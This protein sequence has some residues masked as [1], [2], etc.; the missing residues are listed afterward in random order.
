MST[1]TITTINSCSS[2]YLA[3]TMSTINNNLWTRPC[4]PTPST[5]SSLF[6]TRPS[7]PTPSTDS[8]CDAHPFV[9][10]A[11]RLGY[12]PDL[13]QHAVNTLGEDA[14]TNDLLVTVIS[15]AQ[16]TTAREGD[17]RRV[18]HWRPQNRCWGYRESSLCQVYNPTA[19]SH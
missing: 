5:T 8:S 2:N 18:R 3:T 19:A 12:T 11:V 7:S 15:L 4:S 17:V 16:R 10:Y 9:S 6:D 14:I 1:T 13:A